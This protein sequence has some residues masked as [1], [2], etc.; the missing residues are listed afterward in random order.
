MKKVRFLAMLLA[1]VMVFSFAACGGDT[2]DASSTETV[3]TDETSSDAKVEFT[4]DKSAFV[5][6]GETAYVVVRNKNGS[7]YETDVA[8]DLKDR[9]SKISGADAKLISDTKDKNEYEILIGSARGANEGL[10]E[11]EWKVSHDGNILVITGGSDKALRLAYE[12]FMEQ[13]FGCTWLD[14]EL[15]KQETIEIPEDFVQTGTYTSKEDFLAQTQLIEYPEYPEE[16]IPRDYDYYVK[17]TQGSKTIEIPVYNR[18]IGSN[19]FI[20]NMV[21]G[22]VHRRYAEF[23]FSGDPVTIEV[24]A[25]ISFDK[26]SVMP[27]SEGIDFTV[28]GNVITYTIKEPQTTMIKLNDDRD[29]ILAIFAE[30]PEYEDDIPNRAL[31]STYYFEAGY[32][33]IEGG[34]I[35]LQSNESLYLA[36]G[37]VVKARVRLSGT[38]I[39]IC[40]R[41]TLLES[42]PNRTKAD[43][44][45]YMI[46]MQNAKRVEVSGIKIV[47]AHTFNITMTSCSDV[48]I[49]DVKVLSNQIST[50]GLSWWAKNTNVHVYDCFWHVSDDVFVVGGECVN[51]LVENCIVGSDYGVFTPTVAGD[52]IT[53]KNID[54]FRCGRLVKIINNGGNAVTT[55]ENIYA[56]DVDS[57]GSLFDFSPGKDV[58]R[59]YVLKNVS[60]NGPKSTT[61]I[62]S[63][64]GN[65]GLEATFDNVWVNGK[66]IQSN[67]DFS[68]ANKNSYKVTVTD[69]NDKSAA[70]VGV[71]NVK[72]AKYSA[73]TVYIEKLKVDVAV[74]T[75]TEN[76][77]QYV[78]AKEVLAALD[79]TN[80]KL[81]GN[82]F[83]FEYKD[84]KYELTVGSKDVTAKGSKL[85]LSAP[86][87]LKHGSVCVPLGF[88]KTVLGINAS[89]SASEKRVEI[90]NLART[91][92]L[93][94]NGDMEQGMT[95][96]WITRW[97]TPMYLSTDAHSGKYAMRTYID[98]ESYEPSSAN[99]IYQDVANV[100]RRYGKGKYKLTCWVKKT[101]ENSTSSIIEMGITPYYSTNGTSVK[102]RPTTEWQKME[103][104]FDCNLNIDEMLTLY[105]Y[106]GYA[107]GDYK[108]FIIDDMSMEKIG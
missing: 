41:G 91:G 52:G 9:I 26:V 76:S 1:V 45:N 100:I 96:D 53:F 60:I 95:T 62:I 80:F 68:D 83:T 11:N 6:N 42:S 50:D 94:R 103:Y 15:E 82:K 81:D 64:N 88:F 72:S 102:I 33:E 70:K 39:T 104:T 105:F 55:M 7:D 3:S 56:E 65:S 69:A 22:D 86:V 63:T 30:E 20:S 47:D 57:C 29:T 43:K 2:T 58:T 18:T 32:H 13:F 61:Q 31:A 59:K 35:I 93:L 48:T 99:G 25:N 12:F 84:E 85:T 24:T 89:Y 23:A 10:A 78:S 4:G 79:F 97:F 75:F 40:G 17:V 98:P 46:E 87:V 92:N 44:V 73:E 16:A 27:S 37:A 71:D 34:E 36:P 49:H 67:T 5:A 107:D 106:V 8:V 74:E 54:V 19:Y 38:D 90:E 101:A 77:T 28:K 21:D 14:T 51:N 108:Q 66:R